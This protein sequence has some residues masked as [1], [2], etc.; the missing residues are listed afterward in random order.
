MSV[1]VVE[2]RRG[3]TAA[4]V[5]ASRARHGSNVLTP[6]ERD[7][8]WKLY[9][10]KFDD[11]VIRILIIAAA[12]AITVG[13]VEG[14]VAAEG[15]GIVIAIFLATY[16]AFWNEH[17]ASKEFD[18]LNRTNDDVPVK[19]YRDGRVTTVPRRDVVVGDFILIE[20][21][22]ELP[23]DG[24]VVEAV[25]LDVSEAKL[26]GEARPVTKKPSG[27]GGEAG[28]IPHDQV[29]RGSVAV[30]G[31]G[32][33]EVSAVGDHTEFGKTLIDSVRD[34]DKNRTLNTQLAKLS[35]II[36]VVGFG[37]ALLTFVALVVRAA[38][39]GHL[40]LDSGQ[41]VVA[42]G[43]ALGVAI[44]L[45]KVW[46]PVVYDGF[47]LLGWDVPQPSWLGGDDDDDDDDA[48]GGEGEGEKKGGGWLAG[49]MPWLVAVV[50]GA[51]AF[52]IV[53]GIAV[54]TNQVQADPSTWMPKAAG[55][56]FLRNFMIAV[57][58][59]VVAVPEG[60]AMSVT[61][62]LAYSMRKMTASNTLVRR[63]D[64]CETI[65]A[66]TVICSDKTGTLTQNE[67]RVFEVAVGGG[68]GATT[69]PTDGLK[70]VLVEAISAN[71]TAHLS[72]DPGEPV[73]PV[74]NPTEG[75]LLLWA[76][77]Q[78]ANYAKVR[79]DFAITTQWTFNTE[80]K[81]MGTLGRSPALN[82]PVLHVKGAPELIL[83]RCDWAADGNGSRP[84]SAADREAILKSLADYQSRGMRTIALAYRPDS[85]EEGDVSELATG[86]V[87]LAFAAIAD[88]IR[89]EVP[90]A[91]AT[92][93]EAGVGVKVVT[94]DSPET[95][96][97]VARQIGLWKDGEPDSS[98]LT[99]A[100]FAA[101][102]DERAA[103]AA[104]NLKVLSR[105]RPADKLRLVMLLKGQQHVV[106]VTGD[107]VNDGP[108]LN[109][110]DVGLAM[111]KTGTAVAK[112]AS[113]IILLDDSFG[114]VT[115]AML[116]GRSLYEN[117]QRFILFQLTINVV[118]LGI[119]VLGPF[120]GFDLPLTVMQMLWVNLIMDT[121]AA[122]ALATE[123]PNPAVLRRPPRSPNDFIVSK[124]MAVGIFTIGSIFLLLL[125]GMI[126][127]LPHVPE[128]AG[129]PPEQTLH[130]EVTKADG[131]HDA[132]P[133]RGGTILFTAFVLLQ[134]WNMFNAKCMNRAG[135]V[136]PTL[137]NNPSFLVIAAAILV[138]QVLI[139][140]FGGE[141]FRTVPLDVTEW[142]IL[143]GGTSVVLWAGEGWRLVAG[144]KG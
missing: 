138:G 143:F 28:T 24:K 64:A 56:E 115:T 58:I 52:G 124:R 121:F 80:R 61:L 116:W 63:M 47:E 45:V 120:V 23:A 79:A 82:K 144:K 136:F 55:Q 99:G 95:A 16:L 107:G 85:P 44:A 131:T 18:V 117:I 13:A 29:R 6:P 37:I 72:K 112:E 129:T 71:S 40:V 25:G 90:P 5:Q 119:A 100:E 7:P 89:P 62:S 4:E 17:R 48:K 27:E 9:L 78:G 35:Q 111:G 42:A 87:W 68:A 96:R 66:V 38:L 33:V 91:I 2:T 84:L 81:M 134:F 41:W 109:N 14:K 133:T 59:I 140:Q 3:L 137:L 103:T 86:M 21:G 93:A 50:L 75:A 98:H 15:V 1:T 77:A 43:A 118:A 105:A 49:A 70:G 132:G 65:G 130:L 122:L 19:A 126:L 46:L 73:R 31:Y 53:L 139:V 94:G 39:T 113:D 101:L 141:A 102:P 8:W 51:I 106:A 76:D 32:T 36:G 97:E 60:L 104:A 54:A 34:S 74:G 110:A 108:A 88:P 83:G 57:T 69:L 30:D 12:I 92:C 11:P 142:L 125:V 20:T 67:M 123:P 22:E 128:V 127:T 10:S 26:T 114:S 135:S